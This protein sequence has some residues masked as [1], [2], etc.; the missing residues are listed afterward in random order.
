MDGW[1]NSAIKYPFVDYADSH[2][3]VTTGSDDTS[4]L[5]GR[6]YP[7]TFGNI[8]IPSYNSLATD[9]ALYVFA[10][11]MDVYKNNSAG[12]KPIIMGEAGVGSGGI[13]AGMSDNDTN[14]IWLHKYI[15]SQVNPGGM[16]FIYWYQNLIWDRGFFLKNGFF[17]TFRNFM[18]GQTGDVINKRIPLNNGHYQDIE[19]TLP[20]NVNGW[21]QKD[22]VNGGAHFW[23]YDKSNRRYKPWR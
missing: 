22:T 3:Y 14:G 1:K 8:S 7:F 18:E 11:S 5:S 15:W 20:T 16:Y 13:V 19:L 6:S 12:N 2:S 21:G 23:L 4:W 17:R 10:H 9:L